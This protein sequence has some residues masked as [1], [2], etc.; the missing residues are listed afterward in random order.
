MSEVEVNKLVS[1]FSEAVSHVQ[2]NDAMGI[3]WNAVAHYLEGRTPAQCTHRYK[4]SVDPNIK[5][6][7]W[8]IEEDIALLKAVH[9]LGEE[10]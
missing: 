2:N 9:E 3:S 6:G 7:T 8:K 5:R 10:W 1:K 4:K